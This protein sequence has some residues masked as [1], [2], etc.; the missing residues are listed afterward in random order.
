MDFQIDSNEETTDSDNNSSFSSKTSSNIEGKNFEI[1][2][3][4][5]TSEVM[6]KIPNIENLN[7]FRLGMRK[8]IP[9]YEYDGLYV[10]N[11]APTTLKNLLRKFKTKF[12]ELASSQGLGDNTSTK[13]NKVKINT[14]DLITFEFKRNFNSSQRIY[15]QNKIASSIYFSLMY[16]KPKDFD[17]ER[18]YLLLCM[19]EK[20]KITTHLNWCL[21]QIK[22]IM[23]MKTRMKS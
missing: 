15:I 5:L 19:T 20:K 7:Q 17:Q 22:R 12:N 11:G 23:I 13:N 2:L 21:Y 18:R 14:N 16:K 10:Y 6:K 1:M 8:N 4:V 9:V 3:D